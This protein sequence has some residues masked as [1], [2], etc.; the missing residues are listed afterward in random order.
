M[1]EQYDFQTNPFIAQMAEYGQNLEVLQKAFL[2][3]VEANPNSMVGSEAGRPESLEP[4]FVSLTHQVDD[5]K[6]W[7]L[8]T[9][10]AVDSP[11]IQYARRL[12]LAQAQTYSEGG[13]VDNLA[14]RFDRQIDLV[15]FIG[16]K[17]EVSG[18]AKETK[19]IVDAMKE[20]TQNKIKS[21]IRGIDL[22]LWY[23]DSAIV[24]TEFDSFYNQVLRKSKDA[25]VQIQDK[26]GKRLSYNDIIDGNTVITMEYANYSNRKLIT[27]VQ[28]LDGLVKD[29]IENRTYFTNADKQAINMKRV[30]E[31][32]F[33]TGTG[34]GTI[35]YDLFAS[36]RTPIRSVNGA[37]IVNQAMTAFASNHPKAPNAIA[38]VTPTVV[39]TT[40]E[41]SMPIGQ[42]N[43]AITTF[44]R[45]G[46]SVAT[47]YTVNVTAAG[48]MVSFG[49]VTEGGSPV[50]GQEAAGVR[51]YR[52]GASLTGFQDYYLAK[53]TA[54]GGA[55]YDDNENIPGTSY[56]I[57]ADWDPKQ[58]VRIAQLM[59]LYRLPY[60]V[61]KD[62]FE[63]LIKVYLTL[64]VK[65]PNKIRII[66]NIGDI[67]NV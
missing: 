41:Y 4:Q 55:Q 63:F 1:L 27:S 5:C 56:A 53:S 23:G 49:T 34:T 44:N 14:D 16:V 48:Q 6:L 2:A 3:G 29:E 38:A 37:P 15:K 32:G 11:V 9:K 59:P 47:E 10:E 45:Y 52:R 50:S 54:I 18:V 51:I 67:P 25:T 64:Q 35:H 62:A 22:L 12:D 40:T 61:R 17:G 42:Y 58:V 46:E 60:G 30:L 21:L 43:Y 33:M 8:L 26:R 57:L 31:E 7:Q 13:D 65:N 66:K 36:P 28:A 20:E 19:F 39:P 24:D